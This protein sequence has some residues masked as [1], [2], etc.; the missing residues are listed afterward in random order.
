M[1]KDDKKTKLDLK[2][3]FFTAILPVITMWGSLFT[4]MG[5]AYYDDTYLGAGVGLLI[6]AC[7]GLATYPIVTWV[8][9]ILAT[10]KETRKQ[11]AA[12]EAR[13]RLTSE[14]VATQTATVSEKVKEDPESELI[15]KLNEI[16]NTCYNIDA[17]IEQTIKDIRELKTVENTIA[18]IEKDAYKKAPAVVLRD[19][20]PNFKEEI[21]QNVR[22]IIKICEVGK[23]LG[24]GLLV[25]KEIDN[26]KE[27]LE[28]NKKIY[29]D[30][31]DL[32]RKTAK[33]TTQQ[34]KESAFSNIGIKASIT[35]VEN[36]SANTPR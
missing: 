34:N 29:A 27:E 3:N 4:G 22:D 33:A 1:E 6:A 36:F 26:I 28:S 8:G 12:T 17:E 20:F 23:I 35:A 13:L 2:T 19:G 24:K 21:L 15:A 10:D 30:F 14:D 25:D 11:I 9:E 31:Y 32:I 16:G 7:T 18:I 5:L